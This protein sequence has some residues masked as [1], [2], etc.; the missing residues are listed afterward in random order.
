VTHPR[1][2]PADVLAVDRYL[3]TLLAAADERRPGDRPDRADEPPV[4]PALAATAARLRRDLVRIHPSFRFEERL[5][6]RLA[7][8]VA[9]RRAAAGA[10]GMLLPFRGGRSL[11]CAPGGEANDDALL[12]AIAAVVMG[13]TLLRGGIGSVVGSALGVLLFGLIQT[14]ITFESFVRVR[15]L[16]S[17]WTPII[18]GGLV[19]AF[20]VLQR[21]IMAA[22]RK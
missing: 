18:V 1:D 10:E 15:P 19:L 16:S 14:L 4:D 21:A 11:A 2:E 20:L 7:A 5:A 8:A 3:D 17:W 9:G 13:G 22:S 6:A 12:D